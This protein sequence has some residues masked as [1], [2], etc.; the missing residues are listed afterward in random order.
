MVVSKSIPLV[1]LIA[2][3]ALP[4]H[5]QQAV[6][7][8]RGRVVT[9]RG[10]M[11]KDAE[12]R[13]E[14]FFGAAA[15]T[16]AGQRTFSTRTNAKGEW[17]ILGITS[18]IWLFEVLAPGYAPEIAALPIR[19][20]TASSPNAG[21]Q[22]LLFELVLKPET[23]RSDEQGQILAAGLDAALAGKGDAVRTQFGTLPDE[24]D[25]GF[26]ARPGAFPCWPGR[27]TWQTDSSAA[28]SSAIPVVLSGGT[29][30]RVGLPAA[31]RFRQRL[32]R[33]RRR[34]QPHARQGRA[35]FLSAAIGDLATIKIR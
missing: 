4:A 25:A 14:A 31:A 35:A 19:L 21:G 3:L 17:N 13:A 2:L 12:V 24:A 8:L 22:M 26:L 11:V 1:A 20:L 27:W 6:S 28:L 32:A 15:G 29:R 5:A 34:A 33:L 23:M 18:G 10:E 7:R 9:D 30:P 16:F